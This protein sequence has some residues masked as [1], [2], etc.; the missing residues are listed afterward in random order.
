VARRFYLLFQ[1]HATYWNAGSISKT[2]GEFSY[3]QVRSLGPNMLLLVPDTRSERTTTQVRAP[4]LLGD[5]PCLGHHSGL[6]LG[7]M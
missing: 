6:P 7:H 5:R 1:H 4:L 3:H 2:L